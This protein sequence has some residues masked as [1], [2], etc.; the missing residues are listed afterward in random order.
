MREGFRIKIGYVSASMRSKAIIYLTQ[1]IF[2]F[3]DRSRFEVHVLAACAPD[4]EEFL[5]RG[6]YGV[7]WRA[8]VQH[9]GKQ[10]L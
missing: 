1:N 8:K 4:S 5:V 10:A 7:N 6:M 9:D 3:H 2:G